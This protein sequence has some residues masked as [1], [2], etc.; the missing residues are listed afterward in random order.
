MP[1]AAQREGYCRPKSKRP[2][3]SR[4]ANSQRSPHEGS[5]LTELRR[6]LSPD[7]V[8]GLDTGLTIEAEADGVKWRLR[9]FERAHTE[10]DV[11]LARLRRKAN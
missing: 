4:A 3:R 1:R 7:C 10:Y 5:S 2:W 9:N 6:V 11:Y 8:A